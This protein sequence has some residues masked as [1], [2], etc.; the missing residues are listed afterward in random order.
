MISNQFYIIT[1]YRDTV[2]IIDNFYSNIEV[3]EVIMIKMCMTLE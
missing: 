3:I 1:S 2:H